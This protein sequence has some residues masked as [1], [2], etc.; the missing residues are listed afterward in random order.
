MLYKKG[1]SFELDWENL[2]NRMKTP[3]KKME[4]LKL[5]DSN[6]LKIAENLA[7]KAINKRDKVNNSFLIFGMVFGDH[8]EDIKEADYIWE[9]FWNL[10]DGDRNPKLVEAHIKKV[11]GTLLMIKIAQD[12]GIWEWEPDQDKKN[13]LS[14]NE[15]PDAAI[16]NLRENR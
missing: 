5:R 15:V 9:N 14:I 1:T 10:L 13:K 11:L 8:A 12:S 2:M 3:F 6:L 4:S 16:Y 7:E